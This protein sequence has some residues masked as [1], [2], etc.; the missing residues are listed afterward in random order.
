MSK[1]Y[2]IFPILGWHLLPTPY[3]QG[4]Q[5]LFWWIQTRLNTQK[6]FHR[7]LN[8]T[9]TTVFHRRDVPYTTHSGLMW[10]LLQG[11]TGH[12]R[13][14]HAI[15]T[16]SELSPQHMQIHKCYKN[17]KH[18]FD[19]PSKFIPQCWICLQEHTNQICSQYLHIQRRLE[20]FSHL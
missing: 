2:P 18:S 1:L 4:I 11:T 19:I 8:L 6:K 9:T 7:W 20:P 17:V 10:F 14:M 5:N 13:Q 15:I 3:R 12:M 16:Y